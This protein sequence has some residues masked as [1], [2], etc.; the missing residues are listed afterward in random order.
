VNLTQVGGALQARGELDAAH[1]Q[2][3]AALDQWRDAGAAEHPRAASA[4]VGLA[5]VELDR[6]R[7]DEAATAARRVLDLAERG[8]VEGEIMSRALAVSTRAAAH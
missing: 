5:E 6:G 1:E 4:W 3:R 7:F 8:D 2:Y